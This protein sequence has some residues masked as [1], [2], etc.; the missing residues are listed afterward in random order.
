MFQRREIQKNDLLQKK[1]RPML[2]SANRLKECLAKFNYET[3]NDQ[4]PAIKMDTD[5]VEQTI[6]SSD[7]GCA[8]SSASSLINRSETNSLN[9]DNNQLDSFFNPV[10]DS[11]EQNETSN[12]TINKCDT[13]GNGLHSVLASFY[14]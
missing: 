8:S 6:D 1:N 14:V 11:T 2:Y 10:D 12:T 13:K 9:G 5:S 4:L 3:E 7:Y